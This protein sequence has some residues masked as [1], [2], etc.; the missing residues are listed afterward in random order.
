MMLTKPAEIA[1]FRLLSLKG[2]LK[3][4]V[5]GMTSKIPV[6]SILKEEYG[7]K[8]TNKTVLAQLEN[9]LNDIKD[10]LYVYDEKTH[11]FVRD[12]RRYLCVD[13]GALVL[14]DGEVS[15]MEAIVCKDCAP[16]D[17]NHKILRDDVCE[18]CEYLNDCL[19]TVQVCPLERK[20]QMRERNSI[21][22]DL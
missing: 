22:R 1:L 14:Y 19:R 10:G 4:K 9:L 16:T 6:A 18:N 8:G 3:L 13:C 5:Y 11:R 15:P 12:P 21:V 20:L 17:E 2:S 7:F